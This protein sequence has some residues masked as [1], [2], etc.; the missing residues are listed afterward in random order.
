M[1]GIADWAIMFRKGKKECRCAQGFE[2]LLDDECYMT[3]AFM[4]E[5]AQE[6]CEFT[7]CFD[8]ASMDTS[9]MIDEVNKFVERLDFLFVK[10]G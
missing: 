8:S 10:G 9:I 7:R 4:A 2:D 3:L 6:C 5:A 1:I